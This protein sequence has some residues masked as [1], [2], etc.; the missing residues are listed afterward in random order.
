MAAGACGM[1]PGRRHHFSTN[2]LPLVQRVG[3]DLNLDDD[4]YE[5]TPVYGPLM[6]TPEQIAADPCPLASVITTREDHRF[7]V[8]PTVQADAQPLGVFFDSLTDASR[9]VY[10]PHPL[11][12]DHA[13]ILCD[14]IDYGLS[15]R[16]IA[17]GPQPSEAEG[18]AGYM[19]LDLGVRDSDAKRYAEVDHVLDAS[20]TATFAP[21]IADAW[22]QQGLGSAM[23]PVVIDAAQRVGR[24]RIILMGGVRDDNPRARHFYE[25]FGFLR[26][27]GFLAGG[28]DNH[29]MILHL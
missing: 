17:L 10:G 27:R 24:Q 26:V 13:R 11:N 7:L 16:F 29:D 25:K 15:L 28:V 23:F 5:L 4:P 14:E 6:L 22:Q 19:I 3:G 2:T 9:R 20:S 1:H 12:S 21:V 18:V 8:R